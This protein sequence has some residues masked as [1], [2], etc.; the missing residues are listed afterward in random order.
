MEAGPAVQPLVNMTDERLTAAALARGDEIDA[1]EDRE[2]ADDM[3]GV[4]LLAQKKHRHDGAEHRHQEKEKS[5]HGGADPGGRPCSSRKRP[6]PRQWR[7]YK[8]ICST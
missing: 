1:G 7:R 5:G 4:D 6:A 2:D 3:I 8:D